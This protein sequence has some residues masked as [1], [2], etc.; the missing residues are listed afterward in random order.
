MTIHAIS[1][2][3]FATINLGSWIPSDVARHEQIQQ[4]VVVVVEPARGHRPTVISAQS[5]PIGYILEGPVAFVAIED[6]VVQ[7]GDEQIRETV[8]VKIAGRHAH[9]VAVARNARSLG[10]VGE[11]SVAVIAKQS[12][13][14]GRI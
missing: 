11:S 8:V 2:L 7:S 3:R 1:R 12:I 6:V 5:S 14:E 13:P 4:S 10:H 9:G